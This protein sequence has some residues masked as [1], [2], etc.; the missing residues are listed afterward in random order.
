MKTEIIENFKQKAMPYV[1][2]W[3]VALGS[4]GILGL[5]IAENSYKALETTPTEDTWYVWKIDESGVGQEIPAVEWTSH[6]KFKKLCELYGLDASLIWELENKYNIREWVLLWILIAETSGGNN[7]DYV[8]EGC[9]NL[10]NVGNNDRWN[11]VCFEWKEESIEQ[12]VIT[13]NNKYLWKALTL[14]CLSNAGSCVKYSDTGYRY[15]TSPDNWERT[16]KN[17]LNAIYSEEL[18]EI[19]ANKFSIR[20]DFTSLQ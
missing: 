18:W 10:W 9:Y 14:G 17:V 11:R 19:D 8:W 13:L 12:V 2:G 15:A 7:G 1:I 4:V 5:S 6:E 16:M 20:R 3:V